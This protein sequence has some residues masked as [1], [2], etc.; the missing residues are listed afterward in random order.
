MGFPISCVSVCASFSC[1]GD[2]ALAKTGDGFQPLAKRNVRPA[3]L[4]RA[5]RLVLRRTAAA[6]SAAPRR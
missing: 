4:P 1:V 2:D 3:S 6:L 5:S